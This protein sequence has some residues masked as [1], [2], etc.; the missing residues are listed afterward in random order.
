MKDKTEKE[1][2]E[3]TFCAQLYGNFPLTVDLEMYV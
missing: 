3:E 2:K 1:K